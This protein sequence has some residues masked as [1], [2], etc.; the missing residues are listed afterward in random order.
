MPRAPVPS[1]KKLGN[2][3]KIMLGE[4]CNINIIVSNSLSLQKIVD[5]E[6]N[7][8]IHVTILVVL[9]NNNTIIAY[10]LKGYKRCNLFFLQTSMIINYVRN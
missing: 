10:L 8:E 5:F 6:T 3:R 7:D 1:G 2:P 9:L 4:S